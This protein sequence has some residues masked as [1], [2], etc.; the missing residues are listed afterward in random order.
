MQTRG[1]FPYRPIQKSRM[2]LR[3]GFISLRWLTSAGFA[4]FRKRR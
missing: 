4:C 2:G 3:L 1:L